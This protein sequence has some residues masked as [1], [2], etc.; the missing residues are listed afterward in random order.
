MCINDTLFIIVNMT[1][2]MAH[3]LI[4]HNIFTKNITIVM[5]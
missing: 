3:N 4:V 2:L 5:M 1:V